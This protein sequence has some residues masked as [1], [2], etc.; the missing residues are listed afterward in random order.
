[1]KTLNN[2][3]MPLW[4]W[5]A[6]LAILIFPLSSFAQ[7]H[8]KAGA[9]FP[10]CQNGSDADVLLASGCQQGQAM[11]FIP[12][13]VWIHQ[14]DTITWSLGTDE[15]HTVTFLY[16]PLPAVQGVAPYPAAQQ[17]PSN[18]VGCTAYGGAISA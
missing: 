2:T 9:Q 14:N 11:A 5:P 15:D 4:I 12:N 18:A 8:L 3:K 10:D 7:W 16:Q 17:R 6:L 13:E 1:M